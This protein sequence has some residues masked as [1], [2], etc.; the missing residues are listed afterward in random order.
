MTD[1]TQ[2]MFIGWLAL[3]II[4]LVVHNIFYSKSIKHNIKEIDYYIKN[5]AKLGIGIDSKSICNSDGIFIQVKF[6]K[7]KDE[8]TSSS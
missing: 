6:F 3:Y 1:F 4:N 8:N 5:L 2:G 7:Y